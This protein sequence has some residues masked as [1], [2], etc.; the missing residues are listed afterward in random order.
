VESFASAPGVT[1]LVTSLPAQE[2]LH[3]LQTLKQQGLCIAPSSIMGAGAGL[4]TSETRNPM[5]DNLPPV[6]YTG[7]LFKAQDWGA[8]QLTLTEAAAADLRIWAPALCST[9]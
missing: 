8:H 2:Q 9:V 4:F 7:Q 1:T 3:L 5:L 6:R